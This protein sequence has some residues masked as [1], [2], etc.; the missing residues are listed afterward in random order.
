ML[1]SFSEQETAHDIIEKEYVFRETNFLTFFKLK[2]HG[3]EY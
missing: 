2:M 1:K 3:A